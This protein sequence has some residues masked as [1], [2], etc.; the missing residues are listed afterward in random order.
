[1]GIV[2]DP[3]TWRHQAE[4]MALVAALPLLTLA[5]GIAAAHF[6]REMQFNRAL[7][8]DIERRPALNVAGLA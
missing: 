1:V 3:W 6:G 2:R 7:L 4:M 5:F 8:F